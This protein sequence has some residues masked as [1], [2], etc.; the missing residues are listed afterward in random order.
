M[1]KFVTTKPLDGGQHTILSPFATLLKSLGLSAHD[2]A[3]PRLVN[4]LPQ[5]LGRLQARLF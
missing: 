2:C 5:Q 4:A 1:P 3:P